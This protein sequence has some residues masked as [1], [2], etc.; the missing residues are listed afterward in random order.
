MAKDE[1]GYVYIL[2]NPAFR[3]NW[4][5][6][7]KSSRPVDVRSKE[8]DNTAVPLPFQIYATM[9]TVKYAEAERLVHSY[10]GRFTDLRIRQNRE[11]FNVKPEEALEIFY[12]VQCVIDDAEIEVFQGKAPKSKHKSKKEQAKPAQ[13]LFFCTRAG[14]DARGY[15]VRESGEFVVLAGSELRSGECDS[16][17]QQS[18]EKRQAFVENYCS[19]TDE[20]I[21]LNA[22][23]TFPSPSAAAAMVVGGSSNGWTR[24]KD[25]NGK[26]LSEV[27]RQK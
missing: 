24:W 16:L 23:Y 8:L 2:T 17:S 19:Q 26:T 13:H 15:L 10:I 25:A 1:K 21:I 20:K 12:E 14:S 11:F 7:G 3:E 22:D 6:I 9:S 27:Y 4:V 5:K 18:V